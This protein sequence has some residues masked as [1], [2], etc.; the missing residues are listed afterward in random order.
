MLYDTPQCGGLGLKVIS[1]GVFLS[2]AVVVRRMA[3]EP[4]LVCHRRARRTGFPLK[5]PSRAALPAGKAP[6]HRHSQNRD[7]PEYDGIEYAGLPVE[8]RHCIRGNPLFVPSCWGCPRSI[9]MQHTNASTRN[10]TDNLTEAQKDSVTR[11][12]HIAQI[13]AR[14]IMRFA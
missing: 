8:V 10:A 13:S 6:L 2:L 11:S 14:P 7:R 4:G 1:F 5:V 12:V 9:S 3:V